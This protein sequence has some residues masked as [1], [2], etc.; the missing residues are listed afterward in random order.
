[1]AGI[2]VT[3]IGLATVLGGDRPTTWERLLAGAA[4]AI[5]PAVA[6]P[7]PADGGPRVE[8]LALRVAREAL[9]DAGYGVPLGDWG[10]VVG[11]SR[12]YQADLENLRR[13][14]ADLSTFGRLWPGQLASTL[15][16]ELGTG[17]PVHALSNACATGNWAIAKAPSCW[18]IVPG[19]WW[20]PPKL[21]SRR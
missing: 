12:A 7:L 3:G 18:P 5:A 21:R 16:R 14:G 8:Q 11:S 9:A 17:G 20:W 6:V 10:L 2:A 13:P 15:A 4:L 1:M 19:C